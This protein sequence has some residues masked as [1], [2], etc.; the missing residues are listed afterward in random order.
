MSASR[1]ITVTAST[2]TVG[3]VIGG[4]GMGITKLGAGTL[5]LKWRQYF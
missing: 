4:T 3:G 5:A 1:T 2:L